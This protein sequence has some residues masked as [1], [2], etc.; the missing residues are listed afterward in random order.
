[1]FGVAPL[2]HHV[3]M[4]EI[5]A[6]GSTFATRDVGY[7][8]DTKD[9]HFMPV[10]I[11][12]GPDGALYVADWYD[13]QCNHY[14]N[15]EGKIDK[16][17]GR[18]YRLTAADAKP[19]KAADLSS[20]SS[21]ELVELLGDTNQWRRQTALRLLAD[22]R[23]ATVAPVLAKQLFEREDQ[24]ALESLWALNL[25]GGLDD[26]IALLAL[27]HVNPQVRL[28][29]V[30]LL[31]D[32][33]KVS[34]D[35]A[36]RFVRMAGEE[37]NVE[38]CCQLACS[39]RRLPAADCLAILRGLIKSQKADDSRLPLLIWWGIEANVASEPGA[40]VDLLREPAI[41][42]RPV[43][44]K[45][46]AER[47]MRRFAATGQRKD[48]LVCAE[49][50]RLAPD[51]AGVKR[52]M[53]GF[54][55]AYAGRPMANLPDELAA[56]LERFAGASVV[57]GLRQRRAGAL[58]E[59]LKTLA[60]EQADKSKQLQYVQIL[61]EVSQPECVPTLIQL[62]TKS[63]DNA[64]QAGALRSLSR[65]DDS[66]IV[67]AVINAYG[68][69]TEDVRSAAAALLT[70]RATWARSLLEAV[71]GERIQKAW[72]PLDIVQRMTL[73]SD[74]AIVAK[75]Q[76][77]WPEVKPATNEEL[78]REIDRIAGVL[79]SGVG[80]PKAGKALFMTQCGKCH[81]LFGQGGQVGP[82]L[83]SFKRDDL[84]V[85]LL[86]I[87]HPN[88]EIREGFNTYRVTTD[89][90]RTISGTLAEQDSQTVTLKSAEGAL[91][92]IRRSE[93]DGTLSVSRQSMM[94]EGLLK[95]YSDQQ[96]RDLFGY[97]RMTQPVID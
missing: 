51:D 37:S 56:A 20:L 13:D 69:M 68:G 44:Q 90:G 71:E 75:V 28:W 94:P 86:S 10:D 3:V 52:L 12:E 25:C 22:R 81:T 49:L 57:L 36:A 54:E 29:T 18:V 40:V 15:H 62:A 76:K 65:Y 61:G 47:F 32:G 50:L 7:A 39:A 46:V 58:E 43:V 73:L 95:D 89:D 34:R 30:R 1:L 87:V 21:R 74:P 93:I 16:S 2:L 96:L 70:C 41:W 92:S 82:D 14:R 83:T 27:G 33:G 79:Q 19:R 67:A 63:P 45:T 4:S 11:K 66:K 78:K 42:Q 9:V 91:V 77:H 88:A 6:E 23:D 60:D 97:L 38:V 64:L 55:A 5:A 31:G 26:A 8:V 59:A 48:L 80:K 85:M 53:S 84:A 72:L 17:T 24:L 35:V